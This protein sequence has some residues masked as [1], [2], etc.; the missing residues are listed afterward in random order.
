MSINLEPH[1][2]EPFRA[3]PTDVVV[4]LP[5]GG[6]LPTGVQTSH[7]FGGSDP[8]RRVASIK[9]VSEF[10]AHL[11]ALGVDVPVDDEV[12]TGDGSPLARSLEWNGRRIGNRV[13]IHLM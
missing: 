6:R 12:V 5:T 3:N 10:R 9:T 4:D 7:T 11:S 13:A 8:V 1:D 2:S